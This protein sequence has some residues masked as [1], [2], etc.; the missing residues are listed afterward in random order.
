MA[1][2]SAQSAKSIPPYLRIAAAIRKRI[3]DGELAPGDRVPS[4][5]QIAREWQVALAT[6]TKV[7]TTLRQEGLVRAEPRVGTV[8]A[9]RTPP[10]S[11]APAGSTAPAAPAREGELTR[12]RI[13]RAAIELADREGLAALS[14]RGVAARLG[15]AVMS[16]Y[17][18]VGGKDDLILLMAEAALADTPLPAE[19]PAGCRARL[20]TGARTL[21]AAHRAHPWLAHIGPL[22]RPIALPGMIAFS[23]WNLAALDGQGLDATTMF[24]LNVL[25]YS[26][27]QGIAVHLERQAQA[28]SVTG[29]T[30]NEWLDSQAGALAALAATGRY[31]TFAKVL[32][33]FSETGY[34]LYLDELFEFGLGPLLDGL[35]ALVGRR[36]ALGS[37]CGPDA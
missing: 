1:A 35:T 24:N 4:T 10:A 7:L 18:H 2:K 5:R 34:D 28:E 12:E 14:M 30:E 36:A 33:E 31:P 13:V 3:A 27:V 15:V 8:V 22:T 20:E 32:R 29:M 21:W 23:E 26:Y 9:S 37:E 17:R 25:L 11:P 19:A 16:T 6:A